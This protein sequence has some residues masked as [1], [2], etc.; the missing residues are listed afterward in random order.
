MASGSWRQADIVCPFYKS[1]D[2]KA[3][4]ICE[5]PIDKSRL[6]IT[7]GTRRDYDAQID[8]FCCQH[9][10]K[11]EIYRMVYQAKYDE[12]EKTE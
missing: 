7:F 1:D 8:I 11:C 4:I 9:Y 10:D 6:S 12:G 2:G 3:K 5:G